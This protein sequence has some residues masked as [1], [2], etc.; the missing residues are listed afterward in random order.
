MRRELST[1]FLPKS[2]LQDAYNKLQ[3][4]KQDDLSVEEYT[5]EFDHLLVRYEV[6]EKEEQTIARYLQGL[7]K[8][9]RDVVELQ[10]YHSYH[11]VFKL[12]VKTETRLLIGRGTPS[13]KEP[14]G[15]V[16]ATS[17]HDSS[18]SNLEKEENSGNKGVQCF[19]CKG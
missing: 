14:G 5:G 3:A 10:P 6:N 13:K 18:S 15:K 19:R 16:T 12:A 11:D 1:K 4:F 8:D 2:Y 17:I 9:I 7:R